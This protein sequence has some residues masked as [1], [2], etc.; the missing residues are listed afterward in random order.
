MRRTDVCR[1]RAVVLVAIAVWMGSGSVASGQSAA[2]AR[3]NNANTGFSDP[4]AVA[5]QRARIDQ[6]F[7][8]ARRAADVSELT[9]ALQDC[10]QLQQQGLLPAHVNYVDQLA[11]WLLNRR[12]EMLAQQ[13]GPLRLR[14]D[15]DQAL[16]LERKVLQDFTASIQLDPQWR[17]LHN[18][19]VSYA[20]LGQNPE[21]LADF[22]QAIQRNPQQLVSR[23]NRAELLLDMGR[24]QEADQ[25]YSNVLQM[26]PDDVAARLG[27]AHARFYLRRFNEA[28]SDFDDVIQQQ[29]GN[30]VAY[31]DRADLHAFLGEWE[32]AARDYMV[33]VSLDKS[34]G[35][36]YQSAAWLMATCPDARFRDVPTALQAAQRAIE[37]D[38]YRDYRYLDTLAAAQAN[39]EQFPAAQ[40]TV[41][42][43]LA[44][45]P[46]DVVPEM[47]QRL[48][49]YQQNQPYRDAAR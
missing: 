48:A 13:A 43:A 24:S 44:T 4:R 3:R 49:L 45:A 36:A 46:Q 42:R 9:Q 10:A 28:R 39:A 33:A 21:A 34:L 20:M 19:G 18:R 26:Q 41:Q 27:R 11:A 15:A 22:D 12:G 35:R 8:D 6:V 14:G 23:F 7:A 40:D 16:G 47:R 37:L 32:S 2:T 31:A 17:A 5:E 38:G 1:W 29:P 30:A 25:E